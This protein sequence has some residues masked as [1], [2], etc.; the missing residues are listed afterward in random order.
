LE[1]SVYIKDSK[2]YKIVIDFPAWADLS[3]RQIRE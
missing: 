3:A 1:L 2:G